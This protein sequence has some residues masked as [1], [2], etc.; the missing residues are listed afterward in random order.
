MALGAP[1]PLPRCLTMAGTGL[2]HHKVSSKTPNAT[3]AGLDQPTEQMQRQHG[4]S[5]STIRPL[6]NTGQ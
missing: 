6:I 3:K 5:A 1:N 2:T 4:R